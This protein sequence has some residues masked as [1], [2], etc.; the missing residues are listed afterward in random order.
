MND[1]MF[2]GAMRDAVQIAD[3]LEKVIPVRDYV[4]VKPDLPK[5]RTAAGILL[6]EASRSPQ[7]T[8][9]VIEISALVS[10]A[11]KSVPET[12]RI[13]QYDK[14]IF[15]WGSSMPARFD[16]KMPP[17]LIPLGNILARIE[18]TKS[19]TTVI[20]SESDE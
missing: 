8:G 10:E 5:D 15:H 3:P 7:F 17:V 19:K 12:A 14:V 11:M 18:S 13:K 20:K 9:R 1:Q 6:P 2:S 16:E 4:L